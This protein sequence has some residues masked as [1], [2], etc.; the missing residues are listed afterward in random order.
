MCTIIPRYNSLRERYEKNWS[1][2]EPMVIA[3]V[4]RV[5][6]QEE[7]VEDSEADDQLKVQPPG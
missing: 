7:A 6:Q 3:I 2:L 5:R 1:S 4:T